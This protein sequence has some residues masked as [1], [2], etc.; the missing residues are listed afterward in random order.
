MIKSALR[1]SATAVG[2]V[3]AAFARP[4]IL[5]ALLSVAGPVLMC[6]GIRALAGDAW[7]LIFAGVMCFVGAVVIAKGANRG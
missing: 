3:L 5:V 2:E 6:A 7:A 1:R 4:S